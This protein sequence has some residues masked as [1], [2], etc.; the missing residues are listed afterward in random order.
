MPHAHDPA[1]ADLVEVPLSGGRLTAAQLQVLAELAHEHAGG[2][3]VL[4]AGG[5]GMRGDRTELTARLTG[6]GFD[7]PGEHRHRLLVSP[8]SGRIGGHVDVWETLAGV[9]DRLDGTVPDREIVVGIDDGTGDIAALAPEVGALALPDGRW[10]LLLDGT[11]SGVRLPPG[12]VVEALVAAAQRPRRAGVAATL[13]A[14][15]LEPSEPAAPHPPAP[16]RP[17]G[18]LDQTDGAVTLGG[19]LPG[20]VLPARMAEFLAA[21][22]RPLVVTPWPVLL[23]C[24]L[25]EW[26]AEQ[27]VRVLAPMGLIFDADSPALR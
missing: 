18:W 22:D 7:L 27:V 3:L 5:L 13:A 23:L 17:V 8:L 21:V 4:T 11:D 9:Q 14:L 26:A 12:D 2:T 25:D 6:H 10:A 1:V 19:G 20:A 24:D 15:G 16:A